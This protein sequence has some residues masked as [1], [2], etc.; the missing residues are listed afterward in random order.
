[1]KRLFAASLLLGLASLGFAAQEH[2]HAP[3]DT[4]A[5]PAPHIDTEPHPNLSLNPAWTRNT[6]LA[7]A[8]LFAAAAVVGP[9]IR[10]NRPEQPPADHAHDDHA[11]APHAAHH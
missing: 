6:V 9:I 1:M 8:G 11:A 4:H 3:A 2:G 7:I 10:A 5:A